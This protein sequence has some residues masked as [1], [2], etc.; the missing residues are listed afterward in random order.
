MIYFKVL[1]RHLPRD[2]EEN[3]E[4]FV[5]DTELKTDI[6]VQVHRRFSFHLVY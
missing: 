2:T 4:K 1:D 6:K 5:Q 3:H